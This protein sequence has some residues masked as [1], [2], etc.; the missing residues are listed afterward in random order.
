MNIWTPCFIKYFAER[1]DLEHKVHEEDTKN[2]TQF[3][4]LEKPLYE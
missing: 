3:T 1:K 4:S 2:T